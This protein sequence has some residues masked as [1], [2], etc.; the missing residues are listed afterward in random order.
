MRWPAISAG[1]FLRRL[2]SSEVLQVQASADPPKKI[3]LDERAI[4]PMATIM[5]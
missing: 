3:A 1:S 2:P 5:S 4:M